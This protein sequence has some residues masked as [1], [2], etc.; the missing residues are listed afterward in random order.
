[1]PPASHGSAEEAGP[2]SRAPVPVSLQR[3]PPP[4]CQPVEEPAWRSGGSAGFPVLL[5]LLVPQPY[6]CAISLRAAPRRA[7]RLRAVA[8]SVWLAAKT[9]QRRES[10]KSGCWQTHTR[11]DGEPWLEQDFQGR[12]AHQ[13]FPPAEPQ[14]SRHFAALRKSPFTSKCARS[15]SQ[16]V[17]C[18]PLAVSPPVAL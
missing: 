2:Y 13:D 15:A 12:P 1:M 14:H 9:N 5:S 18:V 7:R 8:D 16:H 17:L 3:C 6:S 10:N 11:T 4:P